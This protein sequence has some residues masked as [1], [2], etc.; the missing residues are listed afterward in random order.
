VS[1]NKVHERMGKPTARGDVTF[2]KE[3]DP[4]VT[5][6]RPLLPGERIVGTNPITGGP[7]TSGPGPIAE[8][9]RKLA[10]K[11]AKRR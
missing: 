1:I 11:E 9:T 3:A 2:S 7:V 5:L 10:E 8:Y 4:S 6:G